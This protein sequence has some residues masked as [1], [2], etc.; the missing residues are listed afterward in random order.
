MSMSLPKSNLSRSQKRESSSSSI[1]G[2]SLHKSTNHVADNHTVRFHIPASPGPKTKT[3]F[4]LAHPPPRNKSKQRLKIR[5]RL[6]LQIHQLTDQSRSFPALDVLPSTIFAPKLKSRFPR[7]F[8][9]RD[10]L[11]PNDLVI[12]SSDSY[13]Q[14]PMADDK[15]ST[16]EDETWESRDIV[17]TICQMRKQDGGIWGKAEIC[18]NHGP[19]W[20]AT[21]LV[22]GS[23]E[24]TAVDENGKVMI[25]RWVLRSRAPRATTSTQG[26]TG[27]E[28]D[29]RFT[30][31]IVNQGNRRHPVIASLTKAGFD[32]HDRYRGLP[33]TPSPTSPSFAPSPV[34]SRRQSGEL[35]DHDYEDHNLIETDEHL[36]SLIVVSGIWVVFREGWS[37]NFR[38]DDAMSASML[39]QTAPNQRARTMARTNTMPSFGQNH[40]L[41]LDSSTSIS[42]APV[43][44]PPSRSN[45]EIVMR[46]SRS[47]GAA[48]LERINRRNVSAAKRTSQPET[49][50]ETADSDGN[51]DQVS[52]RPKISSR[53]PSRLCTKNSTRRRTSGEPQLSNQDDNLSVKTPPEDGSMDQD[54]K[55][56]STAT[57]SQ[58]LGNIQER[59]AAK[60]GRE[61][62]QTL[63]QNSGRAGIP[64]M[65][66]MQSRQSEGQDK[67]KHKKWSGIRHLAHVISCR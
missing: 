62:C 14:R 49:V 61:V 21:P 19:I 29:K 46:R 58:G 40:D 16:S 43:L 37:R 50:D 17:A 13:E 38:Y 5:P 44:P 4:R 48:Y 12:V 54:E 47:A 3:S 52:A 18:L 22:N 6:L 33:A 63:E 53:N 55:I 41:N 20:E 66:P 57:A 31:S 7:V 24:L 51:R 65:A 2:F 42:N 23:Y 56:A 59:R 67:K 60:T 35:S 9:G 11:G 1:E 28:E 25:V 36:R 10:G 32:I 8:H 27:E 39:R 30:F 15:S 45:S 34:P 26:I 64:Q